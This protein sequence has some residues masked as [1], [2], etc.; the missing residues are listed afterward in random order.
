M[1]DSHI[2]NTTLPNGISLFG[3]FDGHGGKELLFFVNDFTDGVNLFRLR[4][5][6]L[7][8]ETLHKNSNKFVKLQV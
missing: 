6:S 2:A 8:E 1:E 3:V 4:Y 5:R 7:R